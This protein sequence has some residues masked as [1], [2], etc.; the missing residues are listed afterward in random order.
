MIHK[1]VERKEIFANFCIFFR[2]M[3]V[4]CS[5]VKVIL[6]RFGNLIKTNIEAP[7]RIGVDLCQ[8]E[9]YECFIFIIVIM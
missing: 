1:Y 9:R 5:A 6:Q 7:P 4:G 2:Y 8:E 3:S